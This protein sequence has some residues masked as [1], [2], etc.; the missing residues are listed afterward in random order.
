LRP[1]NRG[2]RELFN[3]KFAKKEV[4]HEH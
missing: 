2:A 1:L 4:P 3:D